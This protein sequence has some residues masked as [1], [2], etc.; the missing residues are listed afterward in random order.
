MPHKKG[1]LVNR[2][3]PPEVRTCAYPPCSKQFKAYRANTSVCCSRLCSGSLREFLKTNH[4]VQRA[5]T[6]VL[7]GE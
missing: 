2:H 7:Y 5:M 6:E 1:L 4:G 3:H